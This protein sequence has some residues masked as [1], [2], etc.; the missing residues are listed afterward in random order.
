MK[1]LP[2]LSE[3]IQFAF[4]SLYAHKLRTFLTTLGVIIGVTTIITIFTTIE[5]LNAYVEENFTS[6]GGTNSVYISKNPW[7]MTN[8]WWKYRNRPKITIE[9]YYY[10][11]TYSKEADYIAPVLEIMTSIQYRNKTVERV[12]IQA[13]N[14]DFLMA[15]ALK[16]S[17]GRFLTHL[18]FRSARQVVVIGAKIKELLFKNE[19]ALGK[20]IKIRDR[21]FK[22]IGVI[23]KRGSIFGFDMDKSVIVPYFSLRSIVGPRRGIEITVAVKNP[24]NLPKMKAEMRYLM[25]RHRKLKPGEKDNFSINQ[26]DQLTDWYKQTT[27]TLYSIIF[28]IGS[29][30]LLVGGIVITNIMLVSVTERTREI[31]IRKAIGAT[32]GAIMA[33]FLSEA[34][35][36]ALVGGFIGFVLGY[37]G[38]SY[39][40]NLLS[41]EGTITL[42]TILVAVGFSSLVGILSGL[43]PA[44]KAAGLNPIEALRY[45]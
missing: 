18:D 40:L 12:L 22:V 26:Q 25:R 6:I 15:N 9:D 32:K 28:I 36:I 20:V 41:L 2:L 38:A 30:S 43:F 23:A 4:K 11:K 27:G 5:G 8:D 37:L 21:H 31:G 35:M 10:L 3:Y 45:E 24:D 44:R 14:Q 16:L 17:E 7:V 39:I 19:E 33:Q 29:V 13:S 42:R 1:W 34:V